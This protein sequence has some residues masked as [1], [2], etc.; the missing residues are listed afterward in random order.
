MKY[1]EER[2]PIVNI[3][4]FA[5]SMVC[6]FVMRKSCDFSRKLI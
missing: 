3:L 2:K 5:L 4:F 1:T 6:L